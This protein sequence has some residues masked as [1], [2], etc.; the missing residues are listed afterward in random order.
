MT[1]LFSEHFEKISRKN[2]LNPQRKMGGYFLSFSA[3]SHRHASPV[4]FAKFHP[5]ADVLYGLVCIIV[6]YAS[7]TSFLFQFP[8]SFTLQNVIRSLH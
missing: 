4:Q 6:L 1:I 2:G 3:I 7:A 8:H 5:C